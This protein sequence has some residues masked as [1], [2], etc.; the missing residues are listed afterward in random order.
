MT[1]LETLTARIN[2]DRI[3]ELSDDELLLL[4]D[5]DIKSLIESYGTHILMKLP[6]HEQEFFAWVRTND[7]AIW[8]DLWEG[9]E[10]LLVSLSFLKA[11]QTR[12]RGFPICEL[13]QHPNYYFSSRHIKQPGIEALEQIL[14]KIEQRTELSVGE[15]LMF[16]IAARPIDI[17]HFC[18]K[19]GLPLSSGRNAVAQLIAHDWIFHQPLREDVIQSLD[20]LE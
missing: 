15:A 18:F 12:D 8:D 13:E 14:S 7:P 17:W 11:L 5:A 16:E 19:Y 3:L 6:P 2:R 1:I 20:P 10:S 4:S 9:D